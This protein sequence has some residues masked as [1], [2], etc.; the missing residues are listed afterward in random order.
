VSESRKLLQH[1]LAGL[2]YRTQKAL[3]GAPESFAEFDA[4]GKVRTPHELVWH[5]TGLMGYARTM[6]H[7]GRFAP[8]RLD[9]FDAEIDRFHQ[10][11][12]ALHDDFG[13]PDLTAAI[14]DE[15][16]LHGP[17]SDAMTH[18]GQLAML[19]RLEGTPVPSE[20]FIYAR[21]SPDNLTRHQAE[22]VAPD[23]EW[24]P[25]LGHRPPGEVRR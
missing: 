1:F 16:F 3:R 12:R 13:R 4:G 20:N 9:R 5:L 10:T 15:Q 25:D 17:L 19:R 21:I 14:T 24:T 8:P 23:L 11:L 22:P 6:F 2:A 18:V 7:G